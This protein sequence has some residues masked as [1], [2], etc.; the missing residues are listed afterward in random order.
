MIIIDKRRS[1]YVLS[2][3]NPLYNNDMSRIKVKVGKKIPHVKIMERKLTWLYK[4]HI[5]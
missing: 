5:K 4:Y 1:N 3:K 2:K